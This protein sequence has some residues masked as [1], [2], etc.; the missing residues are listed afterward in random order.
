MKSNE[1]GTTLKHPETINGNVKNLSMYFYFKNFSKTPHTFNLQN[2][3]SRPTHSI[4]SRHIEKMSRV[5]EC[6]VTH[7]KFWKFRDIFKRK[8]RLSENFDD[9]YDIS[10][11][12]P[13]YSTVCTTTW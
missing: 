13:I 7:S 9:T 3:L 11:I 10:V 2:I 4:N 6:V 8:F 5:N 12:T 1:V